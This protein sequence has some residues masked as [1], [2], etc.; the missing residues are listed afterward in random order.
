MNFL[1]NITV[2]ILPIF[3]MFETNLTKEGDVIVIGGYEYEILELILRRLAIPYRFVVPSDLT[4]GVEL[5]N[6][7]FS[8]LTGMV[9]ENYA[10]I[11]MSS[12]FLREDITKFTDC[13]YPYSAVSVTFVTR[14]PSEIQSAVKFVYPFTLNLW[15]CVLLIIFILP[16]IFQN[17]LK[18]NSY[19]N[20]LISDVLACILRQPMFLKISRFSIRL[21]IVS[22]LLTA[23]WISQSYSS[24]LLSFLT[25]PLRE[26]SVKDVL[27]LSKA[28]DEHKMK[29]FVMDKSFLY[30]HMLEDSKVH[31]RLL[32]EHIIRNKWFLKS[33]PKLIR[34]VILSE[35]NAFI[36]GHTH[37]R[38]LFGDGVFISDDSLYT[39]PKTI[40]LKKNFQL[41]EKINDM[42]HR[43][44]AS[45]IYDKSINDYIFLKHM[46]TLIK[47]H[48]SEQTI[49][50]DQFKGAFL[51]LI[52]GL[53]LAM[54]VC[55]IE[56]LH[57]KCII[58]L[59]RRK[60]CLPL[61]RPIFKSYNFFS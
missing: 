61:F 24:V 55:F 15:I 46:K 53:G 41:K 40:I 32:A 59:R 36:D 49:T 11:A 23:F 48:D 52:I 60:R 30:S 12:I 38:Y 16:F 39:F 35:R 8:G 31:V 37:M 17:I 56:I 25:I 27:S 3:G 44:T 58:Y 34:H 20:S 28:V 9:T 19:L 2:A 29:A 42:I 26:Q 57:Y 18:R 43:I 5:E 13:T 47:I 14:I 45:G 22:W 51:V 4:W 10:D 50:L 1:P 6:G 54:A 7:H 21:L 33:D